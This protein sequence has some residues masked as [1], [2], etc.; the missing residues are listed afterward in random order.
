MGRKKIPREDALMI[1]RIRFDRADPLEEECARY[2][3]RAE[4][5]KLV[6][7]LKKLVMLGYE[8]HRERIRKDRR[9]TSGSGAEETRNSM[10][11]E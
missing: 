9:I 7:R 6:P 1:Y 4:P 3:M 11:G 5:R 8:V 10:E 2:L